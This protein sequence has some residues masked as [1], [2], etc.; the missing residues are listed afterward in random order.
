MCPPGGIPPKG[1]GPWGAKPE[2][3]F[4]EGAAVGGGPL[5]NPG[6]A[7]PPGPPEEGPPWIPFKAWS[8]STWA[9]RVDCSSSL[10]S[11]TAPGAGRKF[12]S[13]W[14]PI[15]DRRLLSAGGKLKK[16][17]QIIKKMYVLSSLMCSFVIRLERNNTE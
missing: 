14:D 16:Q 1:G 5:E 17:T 3:A 4:P 6:G 7:L 13:P 8:A 11:L 2:G 15:V 10:K 9:C 12:A